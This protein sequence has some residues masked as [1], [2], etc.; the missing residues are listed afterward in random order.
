[1]TDPYYIDLEAFSLARLRHELETREVLPGRKILKEKIPERFAALESMGI[2]SLQ[3]LVQAL[4]TKKKVEAFGQESGLPADYLTIL[5]REANRYL[6]NPVNLG[7]FPGIELAHVE[8]LA[9]AGIKHSKHL[10]D[11]GR[12]HSARDELSNQVSVPLDAV[13]ELV[14]LSDLVRVSGIGPVFARILYQA[15]TD[16]LGKLASSSPEALH[17][18]ILAVN[19]EMGYTNA[20]IPMRDIV[21]CIAVAQELPQA[22]E[23]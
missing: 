12:T 2:D 6:P 1:M 21:Y 3:D 15:G 7:R 5:R 8:K 20:A 9:S 16:T 17:D 11:R 19:L 23:Y 22:I 4:K 18:Q 13:L 14:K 10:F